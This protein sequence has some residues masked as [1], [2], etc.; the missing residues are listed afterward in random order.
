MTITTSPAP[1]GLSQKAQNTFKELFCGEESYVA[2]NSMDDGK[3]I[4]FD[5]VH[6]GRRFVVYPDEK[7]FVEWLESH[8]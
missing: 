2:L 8:G 6:E 7:S 1:K 5:Q 3:W 4:V